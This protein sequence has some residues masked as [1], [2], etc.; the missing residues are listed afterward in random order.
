MGRHFAIA[1][2]TVD[3]RAL[4]RFC[5]ANL[6]ARLSGLMPRALYMLMLLISGWFLLR[7]SRRRHGC[8]FLVPVGHWA[9]A[10]TSN[11][12]PRLSKGLRASIRTR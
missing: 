11:G 6:L 8:G 10:S 1:P 7:L 3:A 12:W 9:L 5:R 4:A 2:W